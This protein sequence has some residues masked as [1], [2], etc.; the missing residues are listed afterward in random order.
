MEKISHNASILMGAGIETTTS[1]LSGVTFLLCKHPECLDKLKDE[2][3][4]RFKSED[5]ITLTSVKNLTYMLACLNE[6]LRM[7]PP[8]P[9][10][11]PREVPAGGAVIAGKW[12]PEKASLH[13]TRFDMMAK[14][15]Y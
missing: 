10:S 5:E 2:V 15:P 8:A 13:A 9:G 6:A 1:L 4:S 12:V 14:R 11:M 3:R 7:Y